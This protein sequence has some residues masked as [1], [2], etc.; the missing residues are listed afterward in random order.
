MEVGR[1]WLELVTS[2]NRPQ[3][4][5]ATVKFGRWSPSLKRTYCLRLQSRREWVCAIG[6]EK[7]NFKTIFSIRDSSVVIAKG[8]DWT[9][10]DRFPTEARVVSL[11]YSVQTNSWGPSRLLSNGYGGLCPGVKLL[12]L[13]ARHTSN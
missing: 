2:G 5:C 7:D 11:L 1:H 9:A 10:E 4:Y 13:E 12:G 6:L 3:A 8:Y